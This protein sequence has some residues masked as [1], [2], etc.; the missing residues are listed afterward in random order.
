MA[1]DK[2]L[3]I[4]CLVIILAIFFAKQNYFYSVNEAYESLLVEGDG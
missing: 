2:K 4:T 1:W 3:V